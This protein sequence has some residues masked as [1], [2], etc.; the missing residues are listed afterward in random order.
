[1]R[2]FF[3]V[4]RLAEN[5]H[6][7]RRAACLATADARPLRCPG[8]PCSADRFKPR[9]WWRRVKGTL[10]SRSD[11]RAYTHRLRFVSRRCV[12]LVLPSARRTR[13]LTIRARRCRHC[14]AAPLRICHEAAQCSLEEHRRHW[15]RMLRYC[16]EALG[17][18]V[19]SK[20]LPIRYGQKYVATELLAL[21]PAHAT[22]NIWPAS[23]MRPTNGADSIASAENRQQYGSFNVR[24]ISLEKW[25]STRDVDGSALRSGRRSTV[26]QGS[27][28][29]PVYCSS[30]NAFRPS[31]HQLRRG[32]E[33]AETHSAGSRRAAFYAVNRQG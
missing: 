4:R 5:T 20:E 9:R 30:I 23:M 19:S 3:A 28:S 24:L 16:C 21:V 2:L 27:L 33:T 31:E 11:C 1:M 29:C 8:G 6:A 10:Q 12:R 22:R 26:P 7:I 32:E 13:R 14:T 17:P 15:G 18:A 25:N